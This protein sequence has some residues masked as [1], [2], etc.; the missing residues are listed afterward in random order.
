MIL[1]SGL[2]LFVPPCIAPRAAAA[3]AAA[4]YVIDR[5]DAPPIGRR[6]SPRPR[7]LD[8]RQTAISSPGLPF[9]GPHPHNLCNYMYY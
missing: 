5:A 9:D 8:L 1:D 2:L 4:L 6:L 7:D 3:A